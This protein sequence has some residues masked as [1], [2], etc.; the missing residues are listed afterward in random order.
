MLEPNNAC[1][2]NLPIKAEGVQFFRVGVLG[3][4]K[5]LLHSL[6]Y[7][8]NSGYYQQTTE[9]R[10]AICTDFINELLNRLTMDDWWEFSLNDCKLHVLMSVRMMLEERMPSEQADKI[11]NGVTDVNRDLI[12]KLPLGIYHHVQDKLPDIKEFLFNQYKQ[13]LPHCRELGYQEV[14]LLSKL[15]RVNIILIDN[16]CKLFLQNQFNTSYETTIFIYNYGGSHWEPIVMQLNGHTYR[17]LFTDS[18]VLST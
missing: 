6:L 16:D 4:G 11:L 3:D 17:A 8:L 13:F 15:Y 12:K 7:L 14:H 5:C 9:T 18:I 1:P 10:Q 2:I